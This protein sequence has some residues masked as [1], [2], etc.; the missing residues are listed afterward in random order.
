MTDIR[1]SIFI[2]K[3]VADR[4]KKSAETAKPKRGWTI[5]MVLLAEEALDRREVDRRNGVR[6]GGASDN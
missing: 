6:A 3:K 1:T 5:Q 2:D 4:I